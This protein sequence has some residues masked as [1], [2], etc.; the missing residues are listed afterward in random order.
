MIEFNIEERGGENSKTILH[1]ACKKRDIEIVDLVIDSLEKIGNDINLDICFHFHV[2]L[3]YGQP[4]IPLL[5]RNVDKSY[6]Q[7]EPFHELL[8]RA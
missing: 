2:L 1:T 8:S 6:I 5:Q 3:C 7:N 4:N